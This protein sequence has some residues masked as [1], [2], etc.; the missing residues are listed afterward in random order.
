MIKTADSSAATAFCV[1]KRFAKRVVR[2]GSTNLCG[3]IQTSAAGLGQEPREGLKRAV[4]R[5]AA[6]AAVDV[7]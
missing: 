6:A 1:L 7:D 3:D 4:T 2:T 5:S